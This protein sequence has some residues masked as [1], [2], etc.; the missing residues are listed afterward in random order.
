VSK[1]HQAKKKEWELREDSHGKTYSML[2][3]YAE[4]IKETIQEPL[5]KSFDAFPQ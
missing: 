4:M 3:K 2:R 5:L 1:S